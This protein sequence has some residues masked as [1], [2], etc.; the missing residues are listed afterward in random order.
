M[1]LQKPILRNNRRAT[2]GSLQ[3]LARTTHD[4]SF[5]GIARK[6]YITIDDR[7][8]AIRKVNRMSK[9]T[10]RNRRSERT[11]P[12]P[13]QNRLVIFVGVVVLA[14][15]GAVALIFISLPERQEAN[16]T[17]YDGISQ[18]TVKVGQVRGFALGDP[19]APVTMMEFADFSCPHCYNVSPAVHQLIDKYVRVGNLRIIYVPVT[20]VNPETSIPAA[21][22]MICAAEQGKGWE[23]HDEIWSRYVT[24]GPTSYRETILTGIAENRLGL[25]SDQ[26]SECFDAD[27]TNVEIER[28]LFEARARGVT[29]TPTIFV[30]DEVVTYPTE[31]VAYNTLVQ[32]IDALLLGE[33]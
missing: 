10:N 3:V 8:F 2:S 27:E 33:D 5:S 11:T 30:N 12:N 20:F 26:F 6:L 23:M 28:Q 17:A 29:S 9:T 22:S 32:R 18:Q 1:L 13:Q 16:S 24:P 21:K 25:D 19:Q 31:D 14:V 7:C 4:I 15:I